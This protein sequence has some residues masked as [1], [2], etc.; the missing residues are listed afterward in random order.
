MSLV[1]DRKSAIFAL[2][3]QETMKTSPLNTRSNHPKPSYF[4]HIFY[5]AW[6]CTPKRGF[7]DRSWMIITVAQFAYFLLPIALCTL[8]FSDD[9]VRVLCEAN[10][11]L[12]YIPIA[13]V[14]L[15]MVWR[16]SC[17]YN[18]R[19]YQQIKE[20]YMQVG[21]AERIR[22]KRHYLLFVAITLIVIV[23]EVW[24]FNLYYERCISYKYKPLI[25]IRGE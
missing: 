2:K 15:I 11:N 12:K 8:L 14:F 13:T 10:D 19:K 16:N 5:W 21:P 1:I 24:L 6:E 22:H 23:M 17:I 4:G 9:T 3:Q 20:Y 25:E 7:P 18:K